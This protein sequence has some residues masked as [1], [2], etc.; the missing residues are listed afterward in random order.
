MHT[1]D[2]TGR[3]HAYELGT[4]PSRPRSGCWSWWRST[5][6]RGHLGGREDLRQR[7]WHPHQRH[8]P[9]PAATPPCRQAT[10]HRVRGHR[11]VAAGDEVGVEAR[12]RR[13]TPGDR[14]RRQPG[15]AIR[16]P[17][18]R[19]VAA[20]IRDELEH[21]GRGDV[22]GILVDDREERLQIM[23]DR[24]QRVRTRPARDKRKVGVHQRIAQR[25]AGLPTGRRGSD[26]A[27]ELVH[28]GL[29]QPASE[30]HGDAT[31]IIRVLGG[32][33]RFAWPVAAGWI[34]SSPA[35]TW[36]SPRPREELGVCGGTDRCGPLA[37][38]PF[39]PPPEQ[40]ALERPQ[41]VGSSVRRVRFDLTRRVGPA[42]QTG[43]AWAKN[44]TWATHRSLRPNLRAISASSRPISAH[45]RTRRSTGRR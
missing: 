1:L 34:R 45:R 38:H 11:R 4:A 14:A 8:L 5:E 41:P 44:R 17:H 32:R 6:E 18:H 39:T 10:R 40:P 30:R 29:L 9:A 25:V 37:P 3:V 15:L 28:P 31:W 36:H 22:D 23:D 26:Q 33:G 43:R 19:P 12:D 7:P 21:I 35:C 20:L 42:A 27:R 2:E 24:S 13:Q 16:D